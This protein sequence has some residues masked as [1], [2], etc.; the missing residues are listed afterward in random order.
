MKK[1]GGIIKNVNFMKS[2]EDKAIRKLLS[3]LNP[4]TDLGPERLFFEAT[5]VDDPIHGFSKGKRIQQE[6]V[7]II[8]NRQIERNSKILF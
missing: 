6:I 8:S 1:Y 7:S 5:L 3:A 2:K 4:D